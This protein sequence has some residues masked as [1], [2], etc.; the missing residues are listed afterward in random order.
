MPMI[1]A[2]IVQKADPAIGKKRGR[3]KLEDGSLYQIPQ[4]LLGLVNPGMSYEINYK[5]DEFNGNKFRVV[6]SI[7]QAAL[8]QVAAPA[9]Q[10]GQPAQADERGT[11]IATLAIAKVWLE[12]VPVGDEQGCLHALRAARRAWLRFKANPNNVESGGDDL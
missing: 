7:M 2:R 12:K 4:P 9:T 10:A 5:D 6:E 3:I 8:Q 11:D 1:V